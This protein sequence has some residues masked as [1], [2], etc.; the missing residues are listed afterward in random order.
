MGWTGE[1]AGSVS[2]THRTV[3]NH[4]TFQFQGLSSPFLASIDIRQERVHMH[5]CMEILTHKIKKIY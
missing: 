1:D 5:T 2:S 3:Y 4:L